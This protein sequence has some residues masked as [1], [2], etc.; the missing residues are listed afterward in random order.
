MTLPPSVP[1]PQEV[2]PAAPCP[3]PPCSVA[4]SPPAP[5]STAAAP[6]TLRM[7]TGRPPDA[8]CSSFALTQKDHSEM[9][10]VHMM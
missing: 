3:S 7:S 1:E 5:S 2:H 4:P 9:A 10:K 6:I 8:F